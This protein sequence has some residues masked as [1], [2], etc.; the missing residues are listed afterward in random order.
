MMKD[1]LTLMGLQVSYTLLLGGLEHLK[2]KT[3]LLDE[4]FTSVMG[5]YVFLKWITYFRFNLWGERRV[6]EVE[7]S[8][9]WLRKLNSW[10]C[11]KES[12]SR[13]SC[14]NKGT[15]IHYVT[16]RRTNNNRHK[17]DM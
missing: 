16:S 14:N 2:I 13:W 10:S 1:K 4:R 3:R 11:K 9:V 8:N 17:G 5:K 12:V 7:E 6:V 15:Q